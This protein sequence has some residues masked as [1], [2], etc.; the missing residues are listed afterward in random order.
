MRDGPKNRTK[1][2]RGM[3][4]IPRR[5]GTASRMQVVRSV[6]VSIFDFVKWLLGHAE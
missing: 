4:G 6:C 2:H 1:G 5:T 3:G